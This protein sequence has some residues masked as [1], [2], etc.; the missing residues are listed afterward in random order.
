MPTWMTCSVRCASGHSSNV[1]NCSGA[2][3]TCAMVTVRVNRDQWRS[4]SC[5]HS[6][7]QILE[8]VEDY[9]D[10]IILAADVLHLP[11][12]DPPHEPAIW[13][14]VVG[15]S[16]DRSCHEE[17]FWHRHGIPERKRWLCR[18]A[19]CFEAGDLRIR[20]VEQLSSIG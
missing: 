15:R 2:L 4:S 5:R 14:D 20:V 13:C 1:P 18:D 10:L 19:H 3:S 8:P 11:R 6:S 9:L 17:Q 7:L 12:C 16:Q